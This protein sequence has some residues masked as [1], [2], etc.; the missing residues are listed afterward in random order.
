VA[1]RAP[2]R[3]REIT[4]WSLVEVAGWC[5]SLDELQDLLGQTCGAAP[6]AEVGGVAR[7]GALTLIRT[8]PG[9]VWVVDEAGG[10]EGRLAGALDPAR[11]CLTPLGHGWRRWRLEG[12]GARELLGKVV[13]L[14]LEAAAR[15]PE[16]AARTGL[17]H[18][19]VLLHHLGD[20]AFDLYLPQTF[21][22]SLIGWL[23]DAGPGLGLPA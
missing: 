3:L 11:G 22:R 8:G 23:S 4:G 17:H 21:A 2:C 9:R 18:A 19:P 20:D 7:Q 5:D 1:E 16:R 14:D 10:I 13:P 12:P 15:A 6:P